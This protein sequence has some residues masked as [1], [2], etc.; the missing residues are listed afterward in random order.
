MIYDSFG[1]L[2]SMQ[3][4]VERV[5][6]WYT[7]LMD[8]IFWISFT[9]LNSILTMV[10]WCCCKVIIELPIC[11]LLIFKVNQEYIYL[12]VSERS[13]TVCWQKFINPLSSTYRV[14]KFILI[15]TENYIYNIVNLYHV[16][17]FKHMMKKFP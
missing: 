8:V 1:I 2:T 11:I 5:L 4:T 17:L 10:I 15:P 16:Q 6:Q 12:V 3:T 13:L 9:F 7:R 14:Y